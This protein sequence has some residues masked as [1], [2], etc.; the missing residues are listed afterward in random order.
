MMRRH[1]KSEYRSGL[2]D[3]FKDLLVTN[4]IPVRY[5]DSVLEYYI[6]AKKHRYTPD[7]TVAFDAVI[8]TKGLWTSKD[9][10]KALLIA[11]QYPSVKILYVFQR[12]QKISKISKTTYLDFCIKHKLEA[13]LFKDTDVIL[14]FIRRN[15]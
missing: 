14:N 9:R 11:D 7:F 4:S 8:E 13:C 3:K 1:N 15:Q 5:E 6:P 2:E 10:A 12:N